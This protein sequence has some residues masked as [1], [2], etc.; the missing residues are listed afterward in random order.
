MVHR[1]Q[2]IHLASVGDAVRSW[3]QS[4]IQFPCLSLVD[5]LDCLCDV[6]CYL[7]NSGL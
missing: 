7:F 1:L 6:L 4:F 2:Q 3:M 5:N